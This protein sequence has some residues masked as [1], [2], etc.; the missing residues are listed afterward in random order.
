MSRTS[1][2]DR[3]CDLQ[4]F[5]EDMADELSQEVLDILRRRFAERPGITTVAAIRLMNE[6]INEID[7]EDLRAFDMNQPLNW[8]A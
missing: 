7:A 5:F 2:L 4:R 6:V 8:V 3:P 1:A